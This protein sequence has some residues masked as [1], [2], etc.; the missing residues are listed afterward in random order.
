MAESST[1]PIFLHINVYDAEGITLN[2]KEEVGADK[3]RDA[4]GVFFQF[5]CGDT[6]VQEG[7]TSRHLVKTA[8]TYRAIVQ[9]ARGAVRETPPIPIAAGMLTS[10]EPRLA[11]SPTPDAAAVAG[12]R[13]T[14]APRS[15]GCGVGLIALCLLAGAGWLLYTRVY[16]PYRDAQRPLEP[17]PSIAVN[18]PTPAL[19]DPQT[20]DMLTDAEAEALARHDPNRYVF[21]ADAAV[22]GAAKVHQLS[23]APYHRADGAKDGFIDRTEKRLFAHTIGARFIHLPRRTDPTPAPPV[24]AATGALP[25]TLPCTEAI[26]LA[27][28]I[29]GRYLLV[30]DGT[31]AEK[32]LRAGIAVVPVPLPKGGTVDAFVDRT[33][34]QWY[35]A[36]TGCTFVLVPATS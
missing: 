18:P 24:S 10:A 22:P 14:P 29:P 17:A 33:T 21:I 23:P 15:G 1:T 36:A 9:D 13:P 4:Q 25:A 11:S 26:R 19:P 32:A 31:L 34:G 3:M 7:R 20:R 6:V 5:L 28:E 35:A 16:V 30:A 12:A 27:T 8:G 2:V